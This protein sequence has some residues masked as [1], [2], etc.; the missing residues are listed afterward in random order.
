VV[1]SDGERLHEREL[2]RGVH[3]I[4]ER[5][6]GAAASGRQELLDRH[7]ERLAGGPLPD[8]EGWRSILADHGPH[9][10]GPLAIRLDGVCVHARPVNYGTRSSTVLE[11][12]DSRDELRFFH[13][14]GRPCERPLVELGEG[15]ARLLAAPASANSA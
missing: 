8:L 5:S 12:G 1:W 15:A 2:A 9:E 14:A 3:W 7:A 4:T 10:P 6:F 13:A 11:L